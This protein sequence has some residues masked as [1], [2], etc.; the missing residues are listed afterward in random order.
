MGV[1]PYLGSGLGRRE[2]GVTV[3]LPH[4]ENDRPVPPD[5][6][7]RPRKIRTCCAPARGLFPSASRSPARPMARSTSTDGGFWTNFGPTATWSNSEERAET[8]SG[9]RRECNL[10]PRGACTPKAFQERV[11]LSLEWARGRLSWGKRWAGALRSAEVGLRRLEIM[12]RI[13]ASSRTLTGSQAGSTRSRSRRTATRSWGGRYS[14][15]VDANSVQGIE[16][17]MRQPVARCR[18]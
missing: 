9:L 6:G 4:L 14:S 2:L 16:V 17:A 8:A 5:T 15:T 7:S 1:A 18:H 10:N 13:M 12:A 3:A 11:T